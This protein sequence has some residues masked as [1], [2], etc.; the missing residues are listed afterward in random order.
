VD[1]CIVSA[2]IAD[3]SDYGHSDFVM[4]GTLRN[5][6]LITELLGQHESRKWSMILSSSR[7][8]PARRLRL[9]DFCIVLTSCSSRL[10]LLAVTDVENELPI[11]RVGHPSVFVA[12]SF[13]RQ[14][15]PDAH[16]VERSGGLISG[17]QIEK[18]SPPNENSPIVRFGVTFGGVG[19]ARKIASK[20]RLF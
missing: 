19:M 3:S 7:F 13:L 14:I 5:R 20:N 17:S 4:F 16:S 6:A 1:F 15:S 11:V 9:E 12:R 2:C 8:G 18:S 10:F